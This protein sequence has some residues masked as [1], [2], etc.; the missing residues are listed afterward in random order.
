M[1]LAVAVPAWILVQLLVLSIIDRR[2]RLARLGRSMDNSSPFNTTKPPSISER[3]AHGFRR[4]AAHT[5]ERV[6]VLRGED[7]EVSAE[8]LRAAGLRSRDAVLIHAFLKLVLPFAGVLLTLLW[9][10]FDRADGRSL[11]VSMSWACGVG[12]ALSKAPDLYLT[13]R[14]NKRFKQVR[15]AFPDMLELLVIASETGLSSGP[16]LS[17]V[18]H[19]MRMFSPPL[20]FELHQLVTELNFLPS[21]HE[22]WQN[23]STRL[24]LPEV[25]IFANALLQAEQYGTPFADAMRTLMHDE[26]AG[27]LL[28]IEEQ[29]GRAPALMTIPLILFI[30]P[31]L[32]IVVLGPAILSIL[33]NII[34][35]NIG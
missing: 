17:R 14:R 16:A 25:S 24:P 20:A 6:S 29:A 30:L 13:R 19:E 4:M 23:L 31:P 26:R 34:G 27:R 35:G 11:L 9:F 15:S 5:F 12:L 7:A 8:L 18:A 2:A 33:D 28:K 3:I 21:R 32:F 1:Y 10:A 22:A